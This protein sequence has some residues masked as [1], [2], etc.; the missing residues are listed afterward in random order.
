MKEIFQMKSKQ[1]SILDRIREVAPS[2]SPKQK[3]LAKYI[4][5]NYR[6]TA[7]QSSTS[8][9]MNAGIS[10]ATVTRLAYALGYPG[11]SELQAAIQELLYQGIS[12][13]Q[14]YPLENNHSVFSKVMN[15]E[16]MI[17]EE[18]MNGI[19]N[20]NFNQAVDQIFKAKDILIV[21]T[22]F[23]KVVA[24]YASIYLNVFKENV[25]KVLSYDPETFN[26][27]E[28]I[29]SGAVAIVFSFPRYPRA[30]QEIVKYLKEKNVSIIGV[31]DSVM[32]PIASFSSILFLIPQK[33]ISFIDPYGAV[34]ALIHSLL[35]GVF[36]KDKE[37]SRA[38]LKKY[39]QF[40]ANQDAYVL[41]KIELAD[42]L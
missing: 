19:T 29:P 12:S 30:T 3:I 20:E 31:T 8:L 21:G 32:S 26:S 5:E 42:L 17:M 2:L 14:K 22:E 15:M 7:F 37:Q 41:E 25:H 40:L 11:Y 34:M 1:L 9:A 10:E 38:K 33:F 35:I 39:D 24:E 36:L 23:N 13:M 16:R 4:A 6:N 18:S 28:S 27:I